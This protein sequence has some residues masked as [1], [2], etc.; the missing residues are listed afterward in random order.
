MWMLSNAN[1]NSTSNLTYNW[2]GKWQVTESVDY[3]YGTS[4]L[5]CN[6]IN[7]NINMVNPIAITA[8]VEL[9]RFIGC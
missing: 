3:N 4:I 1:T 6:P 2:A 9:N 7:V 8:E 5:C